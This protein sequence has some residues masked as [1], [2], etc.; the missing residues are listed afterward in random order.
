MSKFGWALLLLLLC[1]AATAEFV[2]WDT[3][4]DWH[5]RSSE[6]F[7]VHF[8]DA[9]DDTAINALAIAE[10]VH[11]RLLPFFNQSPRHKTELVLVD[12][13]D[14]ANGWATALPFNQIR[15][16]VN[17]PENVGGLEHMD[18]WLHGLILHEYVHILHL[19]LGAGIHTKA[20]KVLGRFPWLFPHQFTPSMLKEGLA[21]Y[22]ETDNE[23][24]YG[25]LDGSYLPMQMRAELLDHGG[26]DLNQTVLSLRDWPS[27]K[28]YVY[29]AYFWHFLA[30]QYGEEKLRQY[31]Q[32]Y[33]YELIPYLFQNS[34]A[35]AVFSKDF[36]DLW[37]DYLAWLNANIHRPKAQE[38]GRALP[39]LPNTEQVTAVGS[40]GLWQIEA[41][42]EDRA[43]IVYWSP[44]PN[45]ITK[46]TFA[47]SKNVT[48][49]DAAA[50][51]TLAVSRRI[52][53]ASG[54]SYNDLYL[55]HQQAGW[56]R[57]TT[58]QRFS[59]VRWLNTHSLIASRKIR[60]IS[61]LWQLDRQGRM[62]KLWQGEQGEVLGSFAV[63]PDGSH[64]V[65]SIKRPRQGW[66]LERFYFNTR[67]W[68]PITA[69]KAIEHQ[70]EFLPDGRLLFSAD[71]NDVFNIYRLE[72]ESGQLQQLTQTATGAF[73]PQ[74]LND[75]L[76]FQRYSSEGFLLIQ[77]PLTVYAEH[78]LD[79]FAGQ[80]D[81]PPQPSSTEV[82]N[83]QPYSA[84]PS[85]LPKYWFP[86]LAFDEGR[87]LLGLMTDGSDALKRHKYNIQ[88]ARDIENDLNEAQLLYQ[89]DNRWSLYAR[90]DH[91]HVQ[92]IISGEEETISIQNDQLS[93]QRHHLWNA[94]EDQLQLHLG[95]SLDNQ[96]LVNLPSH[97]QATVSRFSERLA[98]VALSFD[99]REIYRQVPGVGWGTKALAVYESADVIDNDF[100]GSRS[101][102]S[103]R[104]WLDLPGRSTLQFG[105]QGG[106]SH[107]RMPPFVI[108]GSGSK[109]ASLLFNRH[110]FGLAGYPTGVQFGQH[111]YLSEI[112]YSQWLARIERNLGLWPIGVGDISLNA[113]VKNASAW[114]QS[115]QQRPLSSVGIEL[116][117]D[118]VLGYQVVVPITLGVGRGLDSKRGETQGYLQAQIA[119]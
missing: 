77:M 89:Y 59:K 39:T 111:Y 16:Y 61:E 102:F 76:Y 44:A 40:D 15:L 112:R 113:W 88:I 42:A 49:M 84:W 93:L 20:R 41:N 56:Q 47:Y 19:D 18:D 116:K 79:S 71:Y 73:R 101:Q 63:H 70:P 86:L 58:K 28:P 50:D 82:S 2:A 46:E 14:Y 103:A 7:I 27:A 105:L 57:L 5:S 66:N 35:K 52:S 69:T 95:I 75:Q 21:V 22:L 51:G 29:G 67:A 36:N 83:K 99:N 97:L 23:Q 108:G 25:R 53:Y 34:V 92:Q 54:V 10:Q 31:V 55:W 80:Y 107:E 33:S 1:R 45:Q 64:L 32:A 37:Q 60:G 94:F 104:H 13:Y 78:S 110:Q 43:R 38:E 85:V 30:Q 90:R 6:H 48:A 91:S 26:D 17:P 100:K 81:Y 109:D 8:P 117:M 68:Q 119:F 9:L 4:S 114:S 118:G 3:E 115:S 72:P 98:G 62:L 106:S 96:R 87:R 74:L 11:Q 24:G 12:D 65:A